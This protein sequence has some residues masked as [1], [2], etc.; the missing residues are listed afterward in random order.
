MNVTTV[1]EAYVF[2]LAS[3]IKVP[4][5][6]LQEKLY[7]APKFE[8]FRGG[9]DLMLTPSDVLTRNLKTKSKPTNY[10]SKLT[11]NIGAQAIL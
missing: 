4:R 3:T 9:L 10:R 8:G 2:I 5:D 6:K 1:M 11:T 7:N